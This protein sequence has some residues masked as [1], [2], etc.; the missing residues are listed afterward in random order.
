MPCLEDWSACGVSWPRSD[1]LFQPP[2]LCIILLIPFPTQRSI[3]K[4]DDLR[5][6]IS[7][8]LGV[9]EMTRT[10]LLSSVLKMVYKSHEHGYRTLRKLESLLSTSM[11]VEQGFMELYSLYQNL[12][13]LRRDDDVSCSFGVNSQR[14]NDKHTTKCIQH[15]LNAAFSLFLR[16][17]LEWSRVSVQKGCCQLGVRKRG[18]VDRVSVFFLWFPPPMIIPSA[19]LSTNIADQVRLVVVSAQ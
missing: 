8:A 18:W 3:V 14:Y 11:H 7:D 1:V 5:V 17:I 15:T 19:W 9:P 6:L 16:M 13:L 2:I 4:E 10:Y 12:L